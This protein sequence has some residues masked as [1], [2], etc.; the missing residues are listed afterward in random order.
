MLPAPAVVWYGLM[1]GQ[2]DQFSQQPCCQAFQPI[3]NRQTFKNVTTTQFRKRLIKEKA[4]VR[5]SQGSVPPFPHQTFH[6]FIDL[7]VFNI[8]PTATSSFSRFTVHGKVL[9]NSQFRT[10]FPLLIAI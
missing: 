9:H 3:R 4:E 6:L 7:P 8:Q 5:Q 10:L 1:H 2:C